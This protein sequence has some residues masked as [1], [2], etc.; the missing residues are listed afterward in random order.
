[1]ELVVLP[2]LL[3]VCLL[4]AGATLPEWA[5]QND[6]LAAIRD[7]DELTIVC[8]QK[9]IPPGIQVERGWRALKVRG[10]LEFSLIGVLAE[11][12]ARLA[13]AGV[14][15]FALSTYSTDYILVKDELLGRAIQALRSGGHVVH[16]NSPLDQAG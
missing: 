1:M 5:Q 16:M 7:S 15:I 8:A 11:L 4:P 3:A 6:L 10:P 2:E 12:S 14:S 9:F 13:Q